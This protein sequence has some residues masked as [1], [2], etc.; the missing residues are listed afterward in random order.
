[1]QRMEKLVRNSKGQYPFLAAPQKNGNSIIYSSSNGFHH[2][3]TI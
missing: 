2:I 3:R 1:M